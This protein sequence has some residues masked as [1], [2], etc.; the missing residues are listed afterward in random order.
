MVDFTI[1]EQTIIVFYR[2]FLHTLSS[3]YTIGIMQIEI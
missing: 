3:K 2:H 1:M